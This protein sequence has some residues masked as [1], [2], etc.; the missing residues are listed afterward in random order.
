[1][2]GLDV[3]HC[4]YFFPNNCDLLSRVE[5]IFLFQKCAILS[6]KSIFHLQAYKSIGIDV[7]AVPF[8]RIRRKDVLKAQGIIKEA[9]ES[10]KQKEKLEQQRYK[11]LYDDS[12][13]TKE[14]LNKVNDDLY[15]VSE[16]LALL[17]TEYYYL[18]P[19]A[20]FDFDKINVFDNCNI[21]EEE[22]RVNHLLEFEVAERLLLGAQY[23]KTEIN[24]LDYIYGALECQISVLPPDDKKIVPL[25]LQYIYQSRGVRGKKIDSIFRLDL[26]ADGGKMVN[27]PKGGVENRRLLWHGTKPENLLSIFSVGLLVNAPFAQ[28]TGR[29]FGDGL[30][31]ADVLDK[32]FNYSTNN[33]WANRRSQKASTKQNYLLLCDVALGKSK[34]VDNYYSTFQDGTKVRE[35]DSLKIIGEHVPENKGDVRHSEYGVTIPIG[36]IMS[37]KSSAGPTYNEYVVFDSQKIAIRYLVRFFD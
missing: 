25:I 17:T 30:Y 35:Y 10:L 2:A 1:M 21:H 5:L 8:G 19:K 33:P 29:A 13:Q 14:K 34:N 24:P 3:K 7:D 28:I 32:S 9:K 27:N 11:H 16:K 37:R 4:R 22:V 26:V 12:K 15:E 6:F 18:M 23:R 31:F 36:K 20:G